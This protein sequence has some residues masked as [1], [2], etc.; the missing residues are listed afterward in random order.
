M[1]SLTVS[2]NSNP[3]NI[4]EGSFG[5]DDSINSVSTLTFRV[6]D[7]GGTNHYTKGQP[8][9]VT[10]S[11]SGLSYTG[12]ITTAIE[13]RVSPSTLIKTDIG[14]R[15]NHY[16]AEKR[17][18]DG[19][20]FTNTPAGAIFCHLLNVLSSEGITA[21]YAADRD[22]TSTDFNAG[23]LTSA[24]GTSNV[25][26]GDLE[27]SLA[28]SVV[29]IL[30][31]TT[32]NFSSGTLTNVTAANNTLMPTA[33]SAIKLVA[34]CSQPGS[35]NAYTYVKIWTGSRAIGANET[36]SY[37]MFVL[38]SSPNGQM[39]IDMVFTDGTT[40]RDLAG[41]TPDSQY[42]FPHPNQDVGP[43]GVGQWY[44]RVFS[45]GQFSGKTVQSMMV[46]AEGDNVG[47]YTGYFKNIAFNN[48]PFSF[49]QNT[50][51]QMQNNG[52]SSAVISLINTY[53]L[54]NA[55]RTSTSD[56]IDAAKIVQS[57]NVTWTA[58]EPAGTKFQL[59]YSADGGNNYYTCTKN[60]PLPN[61]PAG[62]NISGKS[63][64]FSEQFIYD[65]A[66]TGTNRP[67]PEVAP[68]LSVLNATV[69][70]SYAATKTDV[71]YTLAQSADWAP[72]TFTNTTNNSGRDLSLIGAIR[73]WDNG[74]QSSQTLFSPNAASS[75]DRQ[76]F[77]I[78]VPSTAN[79]SAISRLDFAPN[80][81]DGT[82]EVDILVDNAQAK[83]GVTY[84]TTYWNNTVDYTCAYFVQVTSTVISFYRGTNSAVGTFTQIGTNQTLNISSGNWHR[85][86]CVFVGNN[87]KIYLDDVL[88]FN[89]TDGT[90]TAAGQ[91]GLRIQ[92]ST[93]VAYIAKFDNFGILGSGAA[94]NGTWVSGGQSLTS[95]GTYGTSVVSWRDVSS[96]VGNTDTV[97]VETSING[98]SSYQTCTNGGV[99]PNLT[100]GQSLT[101][102]NL[103]VRVTLTTTT[104][105]TMPS[106][107]N[108][109]FYVVSQLSA[110]GN[111]ISPVLNLANV[112][113]LGGSVLA[114]NNVALP[115][116]CTLGVDTRIDAGSWTDQSA[117]NGQ[118]IAGLT[119]QPNPYVDSFATDTH[120]NFTS[121]FFTGGAAG[122]WTFDTALSR[123]EASG[124]TNA[125]ERYDGLSFSD[126]YVEVDM[127]KADIAGPGLR[128]VDASNSYYLK[129]SDD[130]SGT[131]PQTIQLFKN[132]GGSAQIGSTVA[133]SF[134]RGTVHR[135]H[136]QIVGTAITVNFDGVQVISTTDSGVAGPGKAF[137]FENGSAQFYSIRVQPFGQD[138]T[139]HT[140]QTRL[141]L[142]STNPLATPQVTDLSLAAFGNTIQAGATIP[143]TTMFHKYIDKNIDDL[144]KA[145]NYWSYFDKNKVA[146]FLSQN[147]LPSPWVGSDG[148][149]GGVGDFLDAG[150]TV[151]DSSDL[152]R[153][154]QIIDNVLAPVTIN[155][156]RKG[157]GISISWTF[158]NQW[159]GVPV[160]TI[161]VGGVATVASVGVKNVD[162]GK[163]FYY[164]VG[165]PTIT[166]DTTG[167]IYDVTFSINFTGP[168]QYLTYSQADDTAGQT[169][170]IAVEGGG[171]G[172]VVNV[173]DGTGL[174]KAQ[175]DV[176]AQA[177]LNQYSKIGRLL[178][179]ATRRVGLA[180]GQIF[181]VF[182][183]EHNL[184][185]TQM[186][187]RS[188]KTSLT[189][190]GP[191]GAMVQQGW[192]TIEATSGAD[193]GD[194]TKLYQR[195]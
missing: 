132:T 75:A 180:P 149:T 92:N 114:W 3:V 146:Y 67:G 100:P 109:L 175:G 179:A 185:D 165:D 78:S 113:P 103:Q 83:I 57:S 156:T 16:L 13:D 31:S 140:V 87:H 46:A 32:S 28:G 10:D 34:T 77:H 23:T 171:T 160:I 187:I 42:I 64:L 122:T 44:H 82:L 189:T 27:L 145:S 8:V 105:S 55:S 116:G 153:N 56:S 125:A 88:Y 66:V 117:Q 50:T 5:E 52:Y 177:R 33:T 110:S 142:A 59:K 94:L 49:T 173:E 170:R 115:T 70:P 161:T 91:C 19:P 4:F 151:E 35:T 54:T 134:K 73:N 1:G 76:A 99:I 47:I 127:D 123:I 174:T 71:I 154:R 172:I 182:L 21:K 150:I 126:G 192:F 129:I 162:T 30:E 93:G 53:D 186:L 166:E 108:L 188:V 155:E 26:D 143:Q 65:P 96:D 193:L 63:L 163:Q 118:A 60:A 139:T 95:A 147:A 191:T 14:V 22:T 133:I 12:F 141:R 36:L 90:F 176:L 190:E 40:F 138:V 181:T 24:V 72:G 157:D 128:F 80:V 69:Q 194:W 45:I 68:I 106:V 168:G 102:I 107:D 86:K 119:V 81:A 159:A 43:M 61:L 184:F 29:S 169:A 18:Y 152:Y 41:L 74:D 104:A 137:M 11:V 124:G 111:R 164:A 37:D 79:I 20:E 135:L 178:K 39:S 48:V 195:N 101:S 130:Q 136:F 9:S 120:A 183:P 144:A 167:P 148:G 62:A 6:R 97:L 2:I 89:A 85:L 158:G 84:R 25:G 131:N 112:G 98:G 58:V 7:D 15:D 17:T 38:P 51:Q 121:T